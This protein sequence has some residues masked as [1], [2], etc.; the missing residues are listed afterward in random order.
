MQRASFN[1]IRE[2]LD[3]KTPYLFDER[4]VNGF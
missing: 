4:T 2:Y 3:R 1:Q